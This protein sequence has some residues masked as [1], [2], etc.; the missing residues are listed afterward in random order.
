MQLPQTCKG[1][2]S[3]LSPGSSRRDLARLGYLGLPGLPSALQWTPQQRKK[4]LVQNPTI[5]LD[6]VTKIA[7]ILRQHMDFKVAE[8]GQSPNTRGASRLPLETIVTRPVPSILVDT[9]WFDSFNALSWT[10]KLSP[11]S[12]HQERT[13]KLLDLD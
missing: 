1:E 9:V 13:L 10:K 8:E 6:L 2:H 11:C 5:S 3:G 12:F 7:D 4:A